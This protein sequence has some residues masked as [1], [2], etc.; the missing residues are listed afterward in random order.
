MAMGSS[1]IGGLRQVGERLRRRR[2]GCPSCHA[3]L[4]P[5]Q[6]W[7]LECGAAASRDV[8]PRRPWRAPTAIVGSVVVLAALGTAVAYHSMSSSADHAALVA[9]TGPLGPQPALGPG[10]GYS[11]DISVLRSPVPGG[12]IL[13]GLP[14]PVTAGTVPTVGGSGGAHLA[15]AGPAAHR[16]GKSSGASGTNTGGSGPGSGHGPS[17]GGSGPTT[18]PTA[19]EVPP[20]GST[21][22]QYQDISFT[23]NTQWQVFE[24]PPAVEDL[25][26]SFSSDTSKTPVTAVTVQLPSAK[27]MP[28]AATSRYFACTVTGTTVSCQ[29]GSMGIDSDVDDLKI[30]TNP[31]PTQSYSGGTMTVTRADHTRYSCTIGSSEPCR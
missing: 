14:A 26:Y 29:G 10:G 2:A 1:P 5:T 16:A 19:P 17:G 30:S 25:T 18:T 7:C 4:A 3:P 21:P 11:T 22:G 28:V 15:S 8:R 9:S 31:Q 6:D 27:P 13:P 23:A 20:G 24:G 12:G